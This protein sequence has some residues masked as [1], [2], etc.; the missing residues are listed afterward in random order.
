MLTAIVPP[1]VSRLVSPATVLAR[2][3]LDDTELDNLADQV[4]EASGMVAAYLRYKPVY[5]TW[6][7]TFT[8]VRGKY[9]DLGARPAWSIA[10]LS[11]RAGTI[12]PSTT[13]RLQRGP[14]GESAIV[15][16]YPWTLPPSDFAA[17]GWTSGTYP[18]QSLL[19]IGGL[20]VTVPDFTVQYVAGW[21]VE[22]MGPDIP[23]GVEA[24][25]VELRRDF[26]AIVQY[27]RASQTLNPNIYRMSNE[28]MQV[29]FF[30][31]KDQDLDPESGLPTALLYSL[32]RYRRAA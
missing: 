16:D 7:E 32:Q 19:E 17:T 31:R 27:L 1:T 5:G 15:R 18:S 13:Y 25:P 29:E 23:D 20:P 6:Q 8:G 9:L 28:G 4:D 2:L 30:R 12:Q 21:W 22:E 26:I 24:F 11:D 10:S 14:L 3:G